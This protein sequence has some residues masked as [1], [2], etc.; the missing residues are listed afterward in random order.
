MIIVRLWE[1]ITA[2][3]AY[4]VLRVLADYATKE[5]VGRLGQLPFVIL[6]IARWRLP[7]SLRVEFHDEW[8]VPDLRVRMRGKASLPVTEL[9]DGIK[10]ALGFVFRAGKI[11]RAAG[12]PSWANRVARRLSSAARTGRRWYGRV[13]V[14]VMVIAATDFMVMGAI[15]VFS[16]GLPGALN[17]T[18]NSVVT[19]VAALVVIFGPRRRLSAHSVARHYRKAT[20]VR[21]QPVMISR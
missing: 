19:A 16:G 15:E 11:A 14:A 2:L 1:L 6:R 7:A 5:V 20:A 17:S 18:S 21:R 9:A 10:F 8:W 4:V 12:E 13:R 3:L